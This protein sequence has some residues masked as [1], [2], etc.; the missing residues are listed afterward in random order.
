MRRVPTFAYGFYAPT[1][2]GTAAFP[3][4]WRDCV[5]AWFP[6]LG[7]SGGMLPNWA[8]A[9]RG[10][11]T[12]SNVSQSTDWVRSE[13]SYAVRC[14][15]TNGSVITSNLGVSTRNATITCWFYPTA[16]LQAN[17]GIVLSR[18][19]GQIGICESFGAANTVTASWTQTSAEWGAITGL[20]PNLNAWNFAAMTVSGSILTVS[21]NG[22]TF[23]ISITPATKNLGVFNFGN[24]PGAGSRFCECLIGEVRIYTRA[25]P[26]S[27]LNALRR[28]RGIAYE[29]QARSRGVASLFNRRRRL[30]VGAGS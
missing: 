12:F 9:F 15:G 19:D 29:L 22:R 10:N 6:G 16:T 11:A 27:Q 28:R 21:L 14:N 17:S 7:Q 30:L 20:I 23:G 13:G 26:T 3:S 4:L 1:R 25:L 8:R 5:G 24:D 2:G 18:S